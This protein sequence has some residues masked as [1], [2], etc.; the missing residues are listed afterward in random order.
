MGRAAVT[1]GEA[2]AGHVVSRDGTRVGYLQTGRGPGIVLVQGAMGDA[3]NYQDLA[4]ALSPSL[5]VY[6]PDRRGRG[7]SPKPYDDGHDIARDVE[8]IDA[9]LEET[10]A[11]YVFGLSSGAVITLEAARTLD[12]VTRAAVFEPPFYADGISRAGV[13]RVNAE[14]ESGDLG[15]ALID[16][17]LTASTAPTVLTLLPRP[18][19]R[20][21]GRA[22]L[23]ADARRRS[24][25]AKLRDL[26]PG[27][28][29]DFNAVGGM[30]GKIDVFADVTK[31]LLLLSGT[32]SPAFLRRSVRTLTQVLPTAEHVELDGLGHDGPWNETRG[33]RPRAVAS[34]L[35]DFFT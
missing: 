3:Y 32:K 31:P 26:L 10:G 8:D 13:A 12:R 29:Y 25:Y 1:T 11:R 2:V 28:R 4:T 20:L 35:L 18:V 33:G 24:P 15:A 21:L 16:S 6:R 34:A 22:V 17:L 27:V 30:D 7:M 19:A 5:T 14:I 23:N 9:I